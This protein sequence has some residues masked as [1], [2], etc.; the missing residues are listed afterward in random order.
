MN[1]PSTSART[2]PD[3]LTSV[4]V[5]CYK[6]LSTLRELIGSLVRQV[7]APPFEVVLVDNGPT[8]GIAVLAAE[9]AALLD[10]KLVAAT[11]GSGTAYAR[12]V[13]VRSSSGSYLLFVDHDDTVNEHYVRAMT[14]ALKEH[15]F[16]CSRVDFRALNPPI[17]EIPQNQFQQTGVNWLS[18]TKPVLYGSGGTL[19]VRR[20]TYDRIG[21]FAEDVPYCDD[22]DLCIRAHLAG[23]VLT[24][25]PDAVLH[26]RLRSGVRATFRQR[27]HWGQ[28]EVLV[29]K[30]H[31]A[32]LGWTAPPVM[33]QLREWRV[34]LRRLPWIR[35]ARGR[36]ALATYAGVRVGR[37]LGSIAYLT[38]FI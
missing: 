15:E 13:G 37:L 4:V 32:A 26:Y 23:V 27:M 11:D 36:M 6:S 25:V 16:V 10:I 38:F 5:P 22:V 30:R 31:G 18:G 12:N 17:M 1:T 3:A 7:D 24:F 19:G 9:N 14:D 34:L 29:Y 33:A 28:A 21:P 20:E 2:F 8:D 35:H